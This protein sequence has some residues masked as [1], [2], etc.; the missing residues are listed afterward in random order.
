M[1][2]KINAKVGYKNRQRGQKYLNLVKLHNVPLPGNVNKTFQ[3]FS[4]SRKVNKLGLENLKMAP[5]V[6]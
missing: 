1:T 6:N 5:S 4:I 3:P 2:S